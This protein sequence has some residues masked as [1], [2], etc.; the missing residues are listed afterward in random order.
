MDRVVEKKMPLGATV[1]DVG[2]ALE[3]G[4][5]RREDIGVRDRVRFFEFTEKIA[6]PAA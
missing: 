4:L 5:R 6:R 3:L 1:A 2:G